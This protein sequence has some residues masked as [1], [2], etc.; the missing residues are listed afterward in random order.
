MTKKKVAI[1]ASGNGSNAVR[2]INYFRGHAN[3]E[4]CALV[5]NNPKAKVLEKT[6]KENLHQV[7]ITN[8][9]AQNGELL[10]EIMKKAK[11]DYIILSGY[12]RKIPNGLIQS[13]P[14]Q[15]INIH[16]ALL[17]KYGGSGMYGIHVHEA[18]KKSND[19]ESGITIHLINEEYDEGRVLAQ[20]KTSLSQTDSVVDIQQKVQQLEHLHFAV[21]IEKYIIQ[22]ND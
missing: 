21:E 14:K 1:F 5:C 15:I 8:K 10:A 20:H 19:H 2:I 18:V 3:I 13:Y 6:A 17:P 11:V 4:V 7:L 12:L 9:E 22:R 16:P